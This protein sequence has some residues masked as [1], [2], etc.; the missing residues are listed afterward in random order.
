MVVLRPRV[1]IPL[2]SCLLA[3]ACSDDGGGEDEIGDQGTSTETGGETESGSESESESGEDTETDTGEEPELAWPTLE[4]DPLV[5]DYC[6]FPY[7]S[8]VFSIADEDSPTGRRAALSS[9]GMPVGAGYVP[10][11]ASFNQSDGFSPSAALLSFLPG[12]TVTGL[13]TPLTIADSLTLDSPTVLLDVET[14]ER[15][16]HWSEL[17]M[18]HDDDDRRA[19]IIRPA[20]RLDPERRYIA[21]IRGVVD[22]GGELL[23]PSEAFAALRDD[24]AS[25]EPSVDARRDLYVDIFGHLEDAGIPRE[26]LQ[27]AWDFSTASDANLTE[28]ALHMRDEGLGLIDPDGP[29]Y[30]IAY[31]EYDPEPGVAMRVEVD[32]SV[33]L[34]LDD[35]G[36]GGRLNFGDDGLPEPTGMATYPVLINVPSGAA[37]APAVPCAFGHGLLG[38]RE[39]VNGG[40]LV[41]FAAEANVL[42]FATDWIGMA[43]DDV[44]NIGNILATGHIDDF[45]TVADRLQQGFLNAFAAMRLV[46]GKLAEDPI[47]QG[48][49]G[50]YIDSETDPWYFGGSQGGIFGSSYMA[51]SPDVMR[52][53]LGVP[54]Q[55]YNLLLNRSIDFTEFFALIDAAYPDKLGLRYLIEL[56]QIEW[57]RAEPSGYS[58]HVVLDPLEGTPAKQVLSLLAIGDHQVTT[59]GGHMMARELGIPQL[60]PA[61]RPDLYGIDVVDGPYEGSV[62]IE[63]DFGLPAE[64]IENVPMTEGDDPHGALGDV[65][66]ALMTVEQFLR[67]GVVES[68]CDGVCDPD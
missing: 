62:M 5:P 60:S 67:T 6:G 25:D 30:E 7:P 68:F 11:P 28:R 61:N 46:R 2:C 56:L 43:E 10:D 19:F 50:S 66:V 45:H 34:Y 48:E 4:C 32:M 15:V 63:Y 1:W 49:N 22:S 33:P 51:L 29:D 40:Y 20:V 38:S 58:R 35:P 47:F 65:P 14:G 23:E 13:P 21:A 26:D 52:G 8:N 39:S 44:S 9:A 37:D 54:G 17:D 59:L 31:V 16:P 27:L 3:L 24:T 55:P 18:S 53:V 36:A 12:A 42:M 57:D 64:P 41:D